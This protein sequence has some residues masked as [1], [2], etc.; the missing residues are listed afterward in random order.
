MTWYQSMGHKGPVLRPRCI[1]TLRA[2]PQLLFYS[3]L[4][5]SILFYSPL[6]LQGVDKETFTFFLKA[7]NRKWSMIRTRQTKDPTYTGSHPTGTGNFSKLK[8]NREERNPRMTYLRCNTLPMTVSSSPKFV[9]SKASTSCK[10]KRTHVSK[11]RHPVMNSILYI[12]WRVSMDEAHSGEA[13]H[14]LLWTSLA[15]PFHSNLY[16]PNTHAECPTSFSGS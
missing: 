9:I 1:G 11:Y 5:Y 2:R 4:L 16:W 6:Y 10:N 15:M 12:N 8:P 13:F 3:I 14:T 7:A